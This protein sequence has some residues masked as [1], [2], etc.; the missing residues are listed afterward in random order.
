M[1][2]GQADAVGC[3]STPVR[4]A[5][6]GAGGLGRPIALSLGAAGIELAIFD[7]DVVELS[8]LHRQ[9]QF[10]VADLGAPK[11]ATLAARRRTSKSPPRTAR[12]V[13]PATLQR[14]LGSG[15]LVGWSA[16]SAT[17]CPTP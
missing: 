2:N 10:T 7:H 4:A 3:M 15:M 16:W 14:W 5:I 9:I 17:C 8:N 1:F 13:C 11:A 12:F 6:V